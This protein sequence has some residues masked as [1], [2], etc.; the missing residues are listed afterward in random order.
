MQGLYT[1]RAL[2]AAGLGRGLVIGADSVSRLWPADGLSRSMPPAELVNFALFGDGGGAVI[3]ESDDGDPGLVLDHI[4]LKTVGLGRKPAQVVRWYGTDGAPKI[5]AADGSIV[6]EPMGEEDYRAI[7][8]QV[9]DLADRTFAEVLA[10]AGWECGEVDFVL[11]P[12]LNGIMSELI[13][14]RLGVTEQQ[15]ISCVADTGNNGNALP[16]I[17][18]T[19]ALERIDPRASGERRLVVVTIESSKWIVAGAALRYRGRPAA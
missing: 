16:F 10:A 14:R 4:V 9:P 13:R 11:V 12:Q 6:R 8:Q 15:A 17:Q 1:A 18:L 19:R 5:Q 3:V 7:A 2:L